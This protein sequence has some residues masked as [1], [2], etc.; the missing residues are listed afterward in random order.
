MI[1]RTKYLDKIVP[2]SYKPFFMVLVDS[3]LKIQNPYLP[4]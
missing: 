2:F 4:A 3:T 1:K